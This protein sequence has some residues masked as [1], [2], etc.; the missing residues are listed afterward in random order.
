[1]SELRKYT[2]HVLFISKLF[3]RRLFPSENYSRSN[4][5]IQEKIKYI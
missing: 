4:N 3:E 5:S 2:T 1:M